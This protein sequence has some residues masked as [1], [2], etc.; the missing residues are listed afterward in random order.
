MNTNKKCL[1]CG[2]Y[3]KEINGVHKEY[4]DG[5]TIVIT[6]IPLL[7]CENCSEEYFS[8]NVMDVILKI[9]N[10]IAEHADKYNDDIIIINYKQYIN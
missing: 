4:V 3:F 9:S 5:K 2:N 8:A 6:E 10:D 1:Y 7:L